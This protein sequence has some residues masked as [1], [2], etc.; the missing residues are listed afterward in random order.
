MLVSLSQK[1][2]LRTFPISLGRL[3]HLASAV[4]KGFWK[5]RQREMELGVTLGL[6]RHVYAVLAILQ[7]LIQ[8]PLVP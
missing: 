8:L 3:G 7:V 4:Y 1:V 2:P 6:P 5:G